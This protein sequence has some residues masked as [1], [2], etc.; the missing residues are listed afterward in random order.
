MV[1][2][3]RNEATAV[4]KK[5]ALLTLPSREGL[6]TP[7]KVLLLCEATVDLSA[8]ALLTLRAPN[9][10]PAPGVVLLWCDEATDDPKIRHY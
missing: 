9:G 6:P 2:L 8:L 4:P 3:W 1:L 7:S 5:S 10:M